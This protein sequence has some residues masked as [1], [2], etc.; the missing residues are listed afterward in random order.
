MTTYLLY[1]HNSDCQAKLARY[2][3]LMKIKQVRKKRNTNSTNIYVDDKKLYIEMK[4]YIKSVK[5]AKKNK[6]LKPRIPEYVGEC[7]LLISKNLSHKGNFS[8][9][10]YI[11][12]MREDGIENCLKYID[13]FNYVKYN[14]P[15]A[16]FTTIMY[17]A[18]VRRILT[19]KKQQN[20]KQA[21]LEDLITFGELNG[22]PISSMVD[23]DILLSF[24]KSN[25]SKK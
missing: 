13:N 2:G 5:S 7:I 16:Y 4:K 25:D 8:N 10:S 15:F 9:Y 19:E 11:D 23:N 3:E 17:Y 21:A 22:T 14:K 12:E 1:T 18:F 24:M 6:T 20:I